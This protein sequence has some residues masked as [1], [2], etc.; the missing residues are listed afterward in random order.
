MQKSHTFDRADI[1]AFKSQWPCH[2]LPDSLHKI[3]FGFAS[4]G[5]LVEIEA[6]ARNGRTLGTHDFDG[7]ALAA[8]ADDAKAMEPLTP[9]LF[10]IER[11]KGGEV[12]A[13]FPCEPHDMSGNNMTCYCQVGQ[14]GACS[15][16]WLATGSHRLAKPEEYADLQRELE[17]EPYAY[18]L[19]V[20]KR[21]QPWMRAEHAKEIRRLRSRGNV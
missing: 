19:Q 8:L 1:D 12:T 18:R 2:G 10:R 5:D 14:H 3:T 4:N 21:L 11:R 20:Y 7:P 16:E 6:K 15:F 9:V 13:V 17:S